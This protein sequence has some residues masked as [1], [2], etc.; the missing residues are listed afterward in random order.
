M[1]FLRNLGFGVL[2]GTRGCALIFLNL[3]NASLWT[4]LYNINL[5][6]NPQFI[7]DTNAVAGKVKF[8]RAVTLP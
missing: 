3:T 8:Y 6:T 5:Q 4:P 1:D 2:G 7:L